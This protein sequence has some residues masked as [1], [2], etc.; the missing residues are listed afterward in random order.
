MKISKK[1]STVLFGALMSMAMSFI[2]SLT[3]TIINVGFVPN[4]FLIWAAGFLIGFVVAFPT[5]L[6]VMPF[7]RKIVNKLTE[8]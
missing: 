3:M 8:E 1:Y 7:I 4:F 2:I 5:A 6:A